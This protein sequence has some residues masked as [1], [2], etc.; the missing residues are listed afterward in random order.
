MEENQQP[1]MIA[2]A[3][4]TGSGKTYIAKK[5]QEIDPENILI[6]SHDHY[7][8]DQSHVPIADRK[9]VNYDE[10]QALDNQLFT[11]HLKALK[12]DE[13]IDM[14]Q[15]DFST[16]TRAK[17]VKK[18]YPK[19]VII[20]EGILI[21]T[22]PEIRDM[23]DLTIF[24]EVEADIRLAR[25]LERDVGERDRT[26]T[27]SINQYLIS[28]QPMHDKYVEPGKDEA[29]LIVNNNRDLSELEDALETIEARIKEVLGKTE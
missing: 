7:Y 13:S 24:I 16:H 21:L 22:E 19:P 10:P 28:A 6:V 8:K 9:T 15:Y 11:E 1:F 29:D 23:F 20:V 14:P 18:V 26:F 2:I 5:L 25:R 12:Q 4:G 27:E 3:G 17:E